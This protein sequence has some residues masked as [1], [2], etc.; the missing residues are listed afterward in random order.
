MSREKPYYHIRIII[1]IMS[2][3]FVNTSWAHDRPPAVC[4]RP[5][6]FGERQAGQKGLKPHEPFS[7]RYKGPI[8]VVLGVSKK[9][10][11]GG[12]RLLIARYDDIPDCFPV[13]RLLN[14]DL[15]FFILD[16]DNPS[17]LDMSAV[18]IWPEFKALR[19]DE[20]VLIGRKN[21]GRFDFPGFISREHARI[22]RR[23]DTIVITDLGSS[24]GTS[25]PILYQEP[26][27]K[28]VG[29]NA[30]SIIDFSRGPAPGTGILR[31]VTGVM[32]RDG[33]ISGFGDPAQNSNWLKEMKAGRLFRFVVIRVKAQ[34]SPDG[35]TAT[36]YLLQSVSQPYAHKPPLL[37]LQT[38]ASSLDAAT[39]QEAV[40]PR[41]AEKIV[42][43]T[44]DKLRE[45][46][47][48]LRSGVTPDDV[49][50]VLSLIDAVGIGA[51]A[52]IKI[53]AN[54]ILGKIP[55]MAT[56]KRQEALVRIAKAINKNQR[57]LR[58]Q[59]AQFEAEVLTNG[60]GGLRTVARGAPLPQKA[61]NFRTVLSNI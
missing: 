38:L 16:M 58:Q 44:A 9:I 48:I 43:N 60:E 17:I 53:W 14:R 30:K 28:V 23:G 2:F 36:S 51:F 46:R 55:E 33:R 11:Q 21:Y 10:G 6:A 3:L 12:K 18:R 37:A 41:I 40:L 29:N 42:P 22:E 31:L 39:Q 5:V 20:E 25:E 54:N 26:P 4:L 7:I 15:G 27:V 49:E 47:A 34:I 56:A 52:E 1:A 32:D 13:K 59:M 57:F 35:Q 45:L 8:V 19:D 61:R 50:R 24:N